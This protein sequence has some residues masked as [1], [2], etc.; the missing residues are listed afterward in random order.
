MMTDPIA[1]QL[2]RIRNALAIHREAVEMPYSRMKL[3]VAEVLER[4]GFIKGFQKIETKP[5][6][7]LRIRLKYGPDGEDIIN[8]IQR[9]SKPGCRVY[10]GVEG[11]RPVK[12][13]QGISIVSTSSG[14]LSDRECRK[15]HVGGE[16]LAT[17]W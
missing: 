14:I 3:G 5:A 13:G 7:T 11:L 4:E 6:E 2:T 1:D 17:V 9:T 10:T 8:S 15:K 16:V 12:R